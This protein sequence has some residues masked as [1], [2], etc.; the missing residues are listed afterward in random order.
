MY[1]KLFIYALFAP[2]THPPTPFLILHL[3]QER[4]IGIN[5]Y[6]SLCTYLFAF[7]NHSTWPKRTEWNVRYGTLFDIEWTLTAECNGVPC[8][9]RLSHTTSSMCWSFMHFCSNLKMLWNRDVLNDHWRMWEMSK[10]FV[11]IACTCS[12]WLYDRIFVFVIFFLSLRHQV[13]YWKSQRAYFTDI[14]LASST[15]ISN[16]FKSQFST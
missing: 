2:Y 15:S 10:A 1:N 16:L 14:F 4:I 9:Y 6:Q 5:S 3:I 11:W 12:C 13:S 8:I 7:N